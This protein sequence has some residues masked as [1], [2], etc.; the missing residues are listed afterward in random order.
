M[1]KFTQKW[2]IMILLE[3]MDGGIEFFWEDWPQHITLVDVFAVDWNHANL[4]DK[5]ESLLANQKAFKVVVADSTSFGSLENPVPV[6]LFKKSTELQSLHNDIIK[7]LNS[8]G[9]VFNNPEYIGEGFIAHSTFQKDRH[10]NK[11]EV[12]EVRE[13]TIVDMFPHGDG[14]QRKLLRT[15]KFAG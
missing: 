7:L 14:Y 4:L 3:Q 9:A 11:G 5:L 12:V 8:A 6:T 1:Q 13:L 15:I 2:T 10:L